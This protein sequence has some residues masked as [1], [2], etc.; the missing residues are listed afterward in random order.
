MASQCLPTQR[1][2]FEKKQYTILSQFNSMS[3]SGGYNN[4][5]LCYCLYLGVRDIDVAFGTSYASC[6]SSL[7]EQR[8]TFYKEVWTK[9]K[10]KA[11]IFIR[12]QTVE[13]ERN[14]DIIQ[15]NTE[16]ILGRCRAKIE[17]G[18]SDTIMVAYTEIIRHLEQLDLTSIRPEVPIAS[19]VIDLSGGEDPFTNL[20]SL[21]A[22]QILTLHTFHND[23]FPEQ[24][25]IMMDDFVNTYK[26]LGPDFDPVFMRPIAFPR[27]EI[28]VASRR[29]LMTVFDLL[30]GL[31]L[32]TE[33]EYSENAYVIHAVLK[34]LDPILTYSKWPLKHAWKN[35]TTD[36]VRLLNIKLEK[37]PVLDIQVIQDCV[38]ISVIEEF[39][40]NTLE[41]RFAMEKIITII[42]DV[43]DEINFLPVIKDQTPLSSMML[44][45][46][47]PPKSY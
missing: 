38:T 37:V 5:G 34:V 47:S 4:I 10:E 25:K 11:S 13:Q 44:T 35:D 18:C 3:K 19:G 39:L 8:R 27:G 7:A 12:R 33:D 42:V 20:L 16:F 31:P 24:I 22:K 28:P 43:K 23:E 41:L 29:I 45:T 2:N 32:L 21:R 9:E 15:E 6:T 17:N 30:E 46:Y 36:I 26:D 14:V 40:K 1:Q